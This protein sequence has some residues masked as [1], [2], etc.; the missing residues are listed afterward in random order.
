MLPTLAVD[1]RASARMQ[2]AYMSIDTAG[3]LRFAVDT[4]HGI[5]PSGLNKLL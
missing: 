2:D 4:R 3:G 1:W 5:Q